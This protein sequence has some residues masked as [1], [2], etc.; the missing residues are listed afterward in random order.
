MARLQIEQ[1]SGTIIS[2]KLQF[3]IS[4]HR[5]CEDPITSNR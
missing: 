2:L 3:Q 4:G 1:I 5:E